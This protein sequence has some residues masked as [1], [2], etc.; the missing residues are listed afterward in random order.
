MPC[1]NP[2][3]TVTLSDNAVCIVEILRTIAEHDLGIPV[4]LNDTVN[5]VICA[6][7]HLLSESSGGDE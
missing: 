2:S 6:Y 7:F 5:S 3:V 4:S 1:K